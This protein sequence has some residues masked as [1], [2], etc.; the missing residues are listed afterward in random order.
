MPWDEFCDLLSGLGP[1]TPLG[2]IVSIR[3]EEDRDTLAAFTPEQR[4]IRSQWRNKVAHQ[5]PQQDVE[6]FYASMK[7]IFRS[8]AGGDTP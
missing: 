1:D 3:L 2:R 5:R 4:N 8:M 7:E 6:A